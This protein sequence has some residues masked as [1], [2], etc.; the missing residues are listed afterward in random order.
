M[1]EERETAALFTILRRL[2]RAKGI[3]Y[4]DLSQ[5]LGVSELTIK[6]LFQAR[7]CK[8]S[9]LVEICKVL[10]MDM[11]DLL[12]MAASAQS[13]PAMLP[14]ATENALAQQQGLMS[15]FILL[16][17]GYSVQEVEYQ[18]GLQKSDLYLYLR[19]LE[20]LELIKITSSGEV[21][22]CVPLPVKWR[23]NGPLLRTLAKV[24]KKFVEAA[25]NNQEQ[26]ES[27]FYSVSRL[28]S[29]GSIKLLEDELDKL[30]RLFHR[31]AELDQHLYAFE[32]LCSYK[33]VMALAPF[34]VPAYFPV[35]PFTVDVS[36]ETQNCIG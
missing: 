20:K 22:F 3:R 33:M 34:D 18:N 27:Y 4:R 16:L 24:N 11:K 30:Y 10:D 12:D 23:L 21:T 31:Q 1:F 9:R 17:N 2:M 14:V 29:E 8:I 36:R 25:M 6:R 7:D 28:L 5:A 15:V 35:P 19:E 13:I 32:E 26:D